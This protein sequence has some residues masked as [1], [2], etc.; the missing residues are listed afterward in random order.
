MEPG[1]ASTALHRKRVDLFGGITARFITEI[2][3]G[4]EWD[5]KNS[6]R[7]VDRNSRNLDVRIRSMPSIVPTLRRSI[8]LVSRITHF[9]PAKIHSL[10]VKSRPSH[11]LVPPSLELHPPSFGLERS[12]S[13]LHVP[14]F[15]LR[16]SSPRLR[17]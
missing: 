6:I 13:E 4:G 14:S 15:E 11:E 5:E 3:G 2:E 1:G 10:A 7:I 9:A 17:A 8:Q 12:S 16:A